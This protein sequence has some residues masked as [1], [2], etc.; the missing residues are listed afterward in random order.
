LEADIVN[1][2]ATARNKYA[3][4]ATGA[5]SRLSIHLLGSYR[6]YQ[7]INDAP[8]IRGIILIWMVKLGKRKHWSQSALGAVGHGVRMAKRVHRA[9][10]TA[11][12]TYRAVSKRVSSKPRKG[13]LRRRKTDVVGTFVKCKDWKPKAF[14]KRS[15]RFQSFA[16]K[17][18]SV[19]YSELPRS[20]ELYSY[21]WAVSNGSPSTMN[22]GAVKYFQFCLDPLQC[23]ST[24]NNVGNAQLSPGSYAILT[25]PSGISGILRQQTAW[26]VSTGP[27]TGPTVLSSTFDKQQVSGANPMVPP[28]TETMWRQSASTM[29]IQ[30]K[31]IKSY[32]MTLE[33]MIVKPKTKIQGSMLKLQTGGW[34]TDA[35]VEGFDTHPTGWSESSPMGMT[36]LELAQIGLARVGAVSG[37]NNLHL[38]TNPLLSLN[39]STDFNDFYKITHK[40]KVYLPPGGVVE[41]SIRH[42]SSRLLK[43]AHVTQNLYD[44]RTSFVVIKYVPEVQ[45]LETSTAVVLTGG[46]P[47]GVTENTTDVDIVGTVN[48]RMG[49]KQQYGSTPTANVHQYNN[50]VI[51]NFVVGGQAT[52]VHTKAP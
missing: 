18:N 7:Y 32:A 25:N 45:L 15:K 23:A 34:Q 8:L 14:G 10:R 50:Q 44:T 28:K 9:Y 31:N 16:R 19:V 17:V 3:Q 22:N 47:S 42:G 26:G 21:G 35:V 27:A 39:D 49:F 11:K 52:S 37:A 12:R 29:T 36:P 13:A 48:Y 24:S 41:K 2:L 51:S 20:T 38:W 5:V 6:G 1:Y 30:F 40:C 46:L 43:T 4:C 33:M